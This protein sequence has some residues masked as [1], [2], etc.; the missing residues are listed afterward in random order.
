HRARRGPG[1]HLGAGGHRG[2]GGAAHR[3]AGAARR[4]RIAVMP[5]GGVRAENAAEI[6]SRTGVRDLHFSGMDTV[7]SPY[8]H[9]NPR[10]SM[11]GGTVPPEDVRRIN[12]AEKIVPVMR[13]ARE[14]PAASA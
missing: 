9:R 7:P 8:R 3:R 14:V 6:L 2:R 10:V 12:S 11:G 4:G 1:A 13:A 5:G